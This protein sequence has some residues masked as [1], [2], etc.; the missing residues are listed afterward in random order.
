MRM[1]LS[2]RRIPDTMPRSDGKKWHVVGR[3]NGW[4]T[5]VPCE[6]KLEA[7]YRKARMLAGLDAWGGNGTR[8]GNT[9]VDEDGVWS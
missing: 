7:H 3:I 5:H 6:T 9:Y 8:I 2:V 1:N 4:P